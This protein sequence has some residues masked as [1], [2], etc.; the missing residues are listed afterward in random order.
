MLR[1]IKIF[2]L[3]NNQQAKRIFKAAQDKSRQ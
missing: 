3:K 2:H 1:W